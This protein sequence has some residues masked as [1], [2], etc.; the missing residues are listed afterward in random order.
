M[1]GGGGSDRVRG[2]KAEE[3]NDRSWNAETT[4]Y[5]ETVGSERSSS[6]RAEERG[7]KKNERDEENGKDE[8]KERERERKRK[9]T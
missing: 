7:R 6:S 1:K 3:Q 5:I 9:E 2:R 8:K 4:R